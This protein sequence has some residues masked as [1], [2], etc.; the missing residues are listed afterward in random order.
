L[1]DIVDPDTRSRMMSGIKGKNTKP[2]LIIRQGLHR[3]GFRFR[4][5][6]P[7]L[8]GKPDLFFRKYRAVV[9]VH[10]CFWHGHDCQLFKVPDTRREF[11][12]QKITRNRDRDGEV[13]ALLKKQG[14]RI[15]I[16]W[17]CALKGK[18][19]LPLDDVLDRLSDWLV[20]PLP[21]LEIRGKVR[22][23]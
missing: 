21:R 12:E 20:S 19:K 1:F 22:C 15:A 17:E 2:E 16:V 7:K 14:W 23:P 13:E 11:W 5:N 9:F 8:P 10:G 6:N 18:G 4:L 3:L